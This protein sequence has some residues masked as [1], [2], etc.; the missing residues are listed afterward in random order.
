MKPEKKLKPRFDF[1]FARIEDF[2][3]VVKWLK[4]TLPVQIK[5]RKLE[6]TKL[7]NLKS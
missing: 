6:L 5:P 4:W 3:K 1:W 2:I 7:D